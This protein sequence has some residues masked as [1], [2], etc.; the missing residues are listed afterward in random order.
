MERALFLLEKDI[1]ANLCEPF[2]D[3]IIIPFYKFHFES[4][5]FGEGRA[6]NTGISQKQ[7]AFYMN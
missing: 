7:K 3:V 6:T 5:N 2:D 1:F 4:E